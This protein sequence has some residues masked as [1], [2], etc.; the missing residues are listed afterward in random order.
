[1]K[2]FPQLGFLLI[3][4]GCLFQWVR[5]VIYA[6][7]T[8]Q[9]EEGYKVRS[10]ISSFLGHFYSLLLIRVNHT[11]SSHAKESGVWDFWDWGQIRST[12]SL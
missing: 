1:M 5:K 7:S 10:L 9:I 4:F 12:I 2:S 8:I 3:G 6:L 11:V